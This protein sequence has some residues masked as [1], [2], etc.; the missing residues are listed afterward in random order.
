MVR[1]GFLERANVNAVEE[2]VAMIS[3]QRSFESSA[4][5][6]QMIDQT[7]RRLTAPR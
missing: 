5:L 1:Q 3:V 7:H 4:R 2:M 6:M